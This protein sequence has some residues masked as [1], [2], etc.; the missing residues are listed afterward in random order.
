MYP[1]QQK[2]QIFPIGHVSKIL[3]ANDLPNEG[4]R[5]TLQQVD[6]YDGIFRLVMELSVDEFFS[7]L[8][9]ASQLRPPLVSRIYFFLY[10]AYSYRMGRHRTVLANYARKPHVLPLA[11]IL[12]Y[13]VRFTVF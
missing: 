2:K 10:S 5:L 13:N 9:L 12:P 1:Y 11:S 3:T 4:V 8:F 7:L 6:E